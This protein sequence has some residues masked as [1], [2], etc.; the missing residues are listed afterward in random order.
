MRDSMKSTQLSLSTVV[1]H[2]PIPQAAFLN[3]MGLEVRVASLVRNAP[4][5]DRKIAIEGAARRL[6][7]P[8]GMG[9]EYRV[10]GITGRVMEQLVWPFKDVDTSRAQ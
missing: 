2:G 1:T 7:D 5:E 4:N 8:S 9:G 6:V 3:R 10:L